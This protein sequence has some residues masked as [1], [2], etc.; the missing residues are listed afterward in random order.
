ELEHDLASV[1]LSNLF[2]VG[3]SEGDA[4]AGFSNR[5]SELLDLVAPGVDINSRGADGAFTRMSGT[6]IA[7]AQVSNVVAKTLA[8]NPELTPP[9]VLRLLQE[10]SHARDKDYWRAFSASP[11]PINPDAALTLAVAIRMSRNGAPDE[12]V[13]ERLQLSDAQLEQLR[14][15]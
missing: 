4:L 5:S 13:A 14:T 2:V 3:A 15:L 12:T 1:E 7:A 6:S 10:T 11:G 9:E 8:L